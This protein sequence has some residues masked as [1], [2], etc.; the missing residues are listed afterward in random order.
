M[1][2]LHGHVDGND[3]M[4]NMVRMFASGLPIPD[5]PSFA[6]TGSG[7]LKKFM[8][9]PGAVPETWTFL[10]TTA[11]G[12]TTTVSHGTNMDFEE[13][14]A[15]GTGL[16]GWS[17]WDQRPVFNVKTGPAA[18][19]TQYA[20]AEDEYDMGGVA[21]YQRINLVS[22]G[23]AAADIDRSAAELYYK[24]HRNNWDDVGT[25]DYGRMEFHFRNAALEVIATHYTEKWTLIDGWSIE[26]KYMA[27]PPL[28]RY[29]DIV[30]V[31]ELN[32]GSAV[33]TYYDDLTLETYV[34]PAVFSVTGSTS[35]YIGDAGVQPSVQELGDIAFSLS[36]DLNDF[37]L[38]DTFTVVVNA[39]TIPA[40]DQWTV[41]RQLLRT[42][43]G[44]TGGEIFLQGKGSAGNDSIYVMMRQNDQGTSVR[45]IILGGA[46]GYNGLLDFYGQ[47]GMWT[48]EHSGMIRCPEVALHDAPVEFWLMV[49]GRRIMA[50]M[51]AGAYYAH[52]YMGFLLTYFTPQQFPYPLVIGG[53]QIDTVYNTPASSDVS[54]YNRAYWDATRD[55]SSK[56]L[57]SLRFRKVNGAW[58]CYWNRAANITD[59]ESY[60]YHSNTTGVYPWNWDMMLAVTKNIDNTIPIFP[61]ILHEDDNSGGTAMYGE[62]EG[63]FAAPGKGVIVEDELEIGGDTYKIFQNNAYSGNGDY[64]AVKLA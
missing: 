31:A 12:A 2:Y 4:M 51:K 56:T 9:F 15:L 37:A 21:S 6:G 38:S 30:M 7:E 58:K 40:A 19:G 49:S 41:N 64:C 33:N 16:T 52:M 14:D 42:D 61:A 59:T 63:L 44:R 5:T 50:V 39:N 26:E 10:C 24:G 20:S 1:A 47:P 13:P 3:H 36:N 55:D 22:D 53:N 60:T 29:V 23:V 8:T 11:S 62:F 25:T 54:A 27:I 17:Q 48:D 35:G 32:D 46:T 57:S 45:N 34:N 28:A 18:S 43:Y